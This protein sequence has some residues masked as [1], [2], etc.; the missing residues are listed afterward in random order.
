MS[1]GSGTDAVNGSPCPGL[2]PHVTNGERVEA[3][4]ITSLSK[5]ASGSVGKVFQYATALS[6]SVPFGAKSLSFI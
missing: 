5:T 4:I 3:S 1:L 6:Q 2:V